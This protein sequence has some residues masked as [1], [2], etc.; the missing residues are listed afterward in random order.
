MEKRG[1]VGLAELGDLPKVGAVYVAGKDFEVGGLD[2]A[3]GQQLFVGGHRF[4]GLGP[5]SAEHQFFAVW[6]EKS[7]PVVAQFE[8]DLTL[9]AAVYVHRPQLQVAAAGGGEHD[10]FAVRGDGRFGIVAGRIGQLPNDLAFFIGYEDIVGVVDAPDVLSAHDAGR[11]RALIGPQVGRG[12]E[13][14]LIAGHE[15]GAGRAPFARADARWLFALCPRKR[16]EVDLVTLV[17]PT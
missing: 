14:R 1:P 12:I 17:A 4:R 16:H 15:V 5:G 7:P 3:F 2:Q 8:G 13:D 9:V 11:F 6:R 10:F